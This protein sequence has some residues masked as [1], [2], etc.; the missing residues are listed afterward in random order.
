MQLKDFR[1]M[2]GWTLQEL[3]EKVGVKHARTVHRHETGEDFPR[4]GI[5]ERYE[6]VTDG[7]VRYED[8]VKLAKKSPAAD[9]TPQPE[10][11]Q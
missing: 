1:S 7:A 4:P 6:E 9:A 10:M 2:K 8:F 5:L 11:S 3:A